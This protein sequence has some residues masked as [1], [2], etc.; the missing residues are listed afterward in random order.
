MLRCC[1]CRN[2]DPT[3]EREQ[4]CDVDDFFIRFPGGT[5][6]VAFQAAEHVCP[7]ISGEC[8]YS[9]KIDLENLD[10]HDQCQQDETS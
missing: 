1:V 10:L 6:V 9:V 7:S 4:A 8:P 3:L 2:S 5:G